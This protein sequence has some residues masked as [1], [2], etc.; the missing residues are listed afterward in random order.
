M[1]PST[2][3]RDPR[4]TYFLSAG[5]AVILFASLVAVMLMARSY[6]YRQMREI[7]R[8]ADEEDLEN[9]KGDM[10][11]DALS[12]HKIDYLAGPPA[13]GLPNGSLF[14]ASIRGMH[15][16]GKL[17]GGSPGGGGG[18]VGRFVFTL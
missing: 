10:P 1:P 4:F 6:I 15:G 7:D 18:L 5:A 16:R 2:P 3:I 17:R 13:V 14:A 9:L 12:P 8:M 11:L